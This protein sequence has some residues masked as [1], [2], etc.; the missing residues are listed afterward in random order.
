MAR[1]CRSPKLPPSPGASRHPLPGGEGL[2]GGQTNP[3][4][5]QHQ[6]AGHPLPGGE[7]LTGGQTNPSDMQHQTAGHPLP[8]GESGC[9][10]TADTREAIEFHIEANEGRWRARAGAQSYHPHPRFAPPSPRGRGSDCRTDK[11]K[12]YAAPN[13]GPPSPRGRVW[14]PDRRTKAMCS[15]K[16]RAG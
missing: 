7:G 6:T 1:P 11:P 2:T 8:E 9:V 3:S 10:A 15:K 14:L 12:R 16:M 13:C 5:M 4:D